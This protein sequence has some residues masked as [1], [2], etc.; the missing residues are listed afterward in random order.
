MKIGLA[1]RP[2]RRIE[3]KERR[4]KNPQNGYILP[5]LDWGE[6]PTVRI[7]HKICMASNLPDI[8]TRAEFQNKISRITIWEGSNFKFPVDFSLGPT[9]Q[10]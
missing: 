10:R 5:I 4:V 7:E 2:G 6:A 3:K 8:I 9:V 1:V